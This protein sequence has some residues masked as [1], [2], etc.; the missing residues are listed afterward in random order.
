MSRTIKIQGNLFIEN[1]EIAKEV[2]SEFQNGI[3]FENN[4][5]KFQQYDAYDRLSE[6]NKTKEMDQVEKEYL[7]RYKIY[8]DKKE[9]KAREEEERRVEEEKRLLREEKMNHIIQNA[10]K[11]GYKLKKEVRQ[12]KTIKLV[13]QKRVY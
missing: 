8:L 11:Y 12:D 10:T 7:K 6:E 5:F 1:E 4:Q 9:Q 3:F 2:I 13:F